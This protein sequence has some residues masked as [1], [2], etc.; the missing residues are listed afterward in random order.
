MADGHLLTWERRGPSATMTIAPAGGRPGRGAPTTF[1]LTVVE[2]R[3]RLGMALVPL[4]RA[5][6]VS[7][8]P[9][10]LTQVLPAAPGPCDPGSAAA[11]VARWAADLA[12]DGGGWRPADPM[13]VGPV[14]TLG[15]AVLPLLGAAYDAGAVP[16]GEVPRWAAPALAGPSPLAGVR[17]AFGSGATRAVARALATGLVEPAGPVPEGIAAIG[18]GHPAGTVALYRLAVALMAAPVAEPDA[19]ARLLVAPGPAHGPERWPGVEQ[20]AAGRDLAA[21]LGPAAIERVLLDAAADH[22]G[23]RMLEEVLHHLPHLVDL[24]PPRPA[25]RLAALRD[26]CRSLL[27]SEPEPGPRPVRRARRRV[28]P[29]D[30]QAEQRRAAAA[31]QREERRRLDE[32]RRREEERAERRRAVRAR[33]LLPP[34]PTP[35]GAGPLGAFRYPEQVGR[36]DGM[37]VS[38]AVRLVLPR[39]PAQLGEWGRRLHSCIASYATTVAEGRSLLVGVMVGDDLRYCLEVTSNGAVRQFLGTR[40]SVVPAAVAGAVCRT[41]AEVGVVRAEIVANRTWLGA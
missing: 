17:A 38:G 25:G 18:P 27:V 40:N 24:L 37:M 15:G 2:G 3:L 9:G 23:P 29:P 13:A 33:A 22:G 30:P 4:N 36:V 8:Q 28:A 14:G 16:L 6:D 32:E 11:V 10:V 21:V 31:Q 34:V 12:G 19:L 7:L 1:V 35:V 41:L 39:S 20:V 26:Q 5:V